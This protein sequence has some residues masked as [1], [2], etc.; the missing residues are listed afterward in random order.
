M[1]LLFETI[2]IEN[3]ILLHPVEHEKRMFASR[4]AL[5]GLKDHIPLQEAVRI[6]GEFSK[7]RIRCRVDYGKEIET[8]RFTSYKTKPLGKFRLVFNDN[9]EYPYKF[10]HRSALDSLRMAHPDVDE[11]ILVKNGR[12]T[13]TTFSNLIFFDGTNWI[14]PSIPLLKGTCRAR[15]IR[16]GK[17]KEGEISVKDIGY[18]SGF[19]VINAMILPEEME[20]IPINAISTP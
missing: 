7:G 14:T 12:I 6:P 13:D 8:V 2:R 17:I 9:I 1:S 10:S 3:G 19:K 5:F 16:E 15:L 4:A 20:M 18:F 11:I